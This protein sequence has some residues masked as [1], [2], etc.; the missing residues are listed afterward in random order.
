MNVLLQLFKPYLTPFEAEEIRN[1]AKTFK[2]KV[3]LVMAN[4]PWLEIRGITDLRAKA[5]IEGLRV[6]G[7]RFHVV[8]GKKK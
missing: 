6:R 5:L 4:W 3:H 8:E 2:P 1:E 7:V